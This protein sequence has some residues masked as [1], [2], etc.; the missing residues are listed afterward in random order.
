MHIVWGLLTDRYVQQT[1]FLY[2]Q[3]SSKDI[4]LLEFPSITQNQELW[5]FIEN[6]MQNICN[7]NA[8]FVFAKLQPSFSISRK[9]FTLIE[10]YYNE[11]SYYWRG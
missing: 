8:A 2:L 5:R 10:Q 11:V 7:F 9:D 6:K 1:H 3:V 4:K